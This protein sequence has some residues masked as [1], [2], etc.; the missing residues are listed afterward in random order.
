M[1]KEK[2]IALKIILTVFVAQMAMFVFVAGSSATVNSVIGNIFG[3][4]AF[5]ALWLINLFG[6]LYKTFSHTAL[7][8]DNA[9][10]RNLAIVSVL[11]SAGEATSFFFI[12][13]FIRTCQ[14]VT[15]ILR[16]KKPNIA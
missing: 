11:I 15:Q 12:Y 7:L 4:A 8:L 3:I 13:L 6:N 14:K 9:P 10:L 5:L 1:D 16:G 2:S